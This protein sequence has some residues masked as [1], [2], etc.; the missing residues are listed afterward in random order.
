M[1]GDKMKRIYIGKDELGEVLKYVEENNLSL[2]LGSICNLSTLKSLIKSVKDL[3]IV[4]DFV[5]Y[6]ERKGDVEIALTTKH[7]VVIFYKDEDSV[8]K[9]LKEIYNNENI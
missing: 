5:Y 6:K 9:R 1:I 8:D 7:N 2:I 4:F 3:L